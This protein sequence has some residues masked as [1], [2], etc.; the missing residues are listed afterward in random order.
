MFKEEEEEDMFKEEEEEDMFKEEEEAPAEDPMDKAAKTMFRER[1]RRLWDMFKNSHWHLVPFMMEFQ[2]LES[3]VLADITKNPQGLAM[4]TRHYLQCTQ[5]RNRVT[6]MRCSAQ[7]KEAPL[8]R[9]EKAVAKAE[10]LPAAKSGAV[11]DVREMADAIGVLIG[12][13]V[14]KEVAKQIEKHLQTMGLPEEDSPSRSSR[15][16]RSRPR[17]P[18]QERRA[19]S[20]RETVAPYIVANVPGGRVCAKYPQASRPPASRPSAIPSTP[21]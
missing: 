1:R 13:S 18:P 12:H 21:R 6:F 7:L 4:H 19:H 16:S 5:C 8:A 2:P 10:R 17:R 15:S 9:W 14:A 3:R 11:S 20:G